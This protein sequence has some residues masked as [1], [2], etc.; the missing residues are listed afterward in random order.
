MEKIFGSES[1]INELEE[2][3]SDM[4]EN[5][6]NQQFMENLK[7]QELSYIKKNTKKGINKSSEPY[8]SK[9]KSSYTKNHL[10]QGRIKPFAEMTKSKQTK[11]K[12]LKWLLYSSKV[13]K[14]KLLKIMVKFN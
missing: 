12:L 7:D 1:T 10:K 11:V 14:N 13:N 8:A 9:F 2:Y 6:Y 3:D 4:S 5:E